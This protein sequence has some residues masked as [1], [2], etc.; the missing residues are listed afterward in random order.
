MSSTCQRSI[1]EQRQQPGVVGMGDA[2]PRDEMPKPQAEHM[3][4]VKNVRLVK[5]SRPASVTGFNRRNALLPLG[6]AFWLPSS[7]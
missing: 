2:L 3:P 1:P 4:H 5:A 7:P 6:L